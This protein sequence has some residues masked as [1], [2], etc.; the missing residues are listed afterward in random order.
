MFKGITAKM[1]LFSLR[2]DKF[3]E[4]NAKK[5]LLS[6]TMPKW[7]DF[8]RNNCEKAFIPFHPIGNE[9]INAKTQLLTSV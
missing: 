8:A 9:K 7:T 6:A 2:P 1:H 3:E 5:Q 4:I